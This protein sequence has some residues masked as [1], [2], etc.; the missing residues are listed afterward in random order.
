LRLFLAI[1][2]AAAI[3]LSSSFSHAATRSPSGHQR[4][5]AL[6]PAT[7]NDSNLTP[8]L[9]KG[10]RGA[11]VVRAQVL[12]DRA[13]FSVGEI[14][15][16]F[17]ENMRKA[18]VGFQDG[19]GLKATGRIDGDTWAA[20]GSTEA[21]VLVPYA[22]T[23][24]DAAGP[25][26]KI[27]ANIM[28]R[29][30][31]PY[32]G[33]ESLEEAL[34]EKFHL[35]PQLLRDLNRGKPLK[36]GEEITVPDVLSAKPPPKAASI[37]L[38]KGGKALLALDAKG[39]VIA[40]FPISVG[41]KRDELPAGKLKITT[42]VTDPAFDYNPALIWDAKATD[43]KTRIAPGPNNP[44]GVLWMGLSK[45]HYGIHGTPQPSRVGRTETHGCIH[46]TNWD[47]HKLSAIASAGLAVDVQI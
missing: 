27:P 39:R 38:L 5:S 30:S 44:V 7:I 36:A 9:A 46:L 31:L 3:L 26:V 18:V 23:E 33:Y 24:K 22:I 35:S 42:E 17:G 29:A 16:G 13:W 11:A 25:F 40:Q 21:A 45:P 41:G 14:D 47:A 34:A 43:S 20:L 15:G 4:S 10:A 1:A 37:Q 6:D 28:E 32:L 2:A 12:L 19:H 8:V